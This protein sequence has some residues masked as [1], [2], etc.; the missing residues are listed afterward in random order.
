MEIKEKP[1]A[2]FFKWINLSL[3]SVLKHPDINLG[4]FISGCFNTLF[5]ESLIPL[6]KMK[7]YLFNYY[8]TNDTLPVVDK[9]FVKSCM[10]I[11]IV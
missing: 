11:T 5:K 10:K 8:E 9:V 6:K 7:L 3:K 2:G 1:P 4:V